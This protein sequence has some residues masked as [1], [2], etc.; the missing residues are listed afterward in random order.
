R[1][2]DLA[3]TVRFHLRPLGVRQYKAIHPECESQLQQNGN[4]KSPHPL[5]QARRQ[6][7]AWVEDY[8]RH[9]P[10]S[11]L[12]YQTPANFAAKLHKQW[13]ASLRPTDCAAQAIA[14]TAFMRNKV[15]RL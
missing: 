4:P 9:R 6:I 11:A 3:Q 1:V 15:A 7:A 10:H 2:G 8:N 5:G 13:P 14:S 12:G